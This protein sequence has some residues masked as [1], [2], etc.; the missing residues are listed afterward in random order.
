M[1]LMFSP[2]FVGIFVNKDGVVSQVD[3]VGDAYEMGVRDKWALS[4]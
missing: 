4:E 2:G 3:K 1:E